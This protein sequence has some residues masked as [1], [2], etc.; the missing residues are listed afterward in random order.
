[1]DPRKDRI[2]ELDLLR[3]FAIMAV[4]GVHTITFFTIDSGVTISSVT[5]T[6]LGC[7]VSLGVPIFF[8]VSG[9]VLSLR[10]RP[11]VNYQSF[12]R[13]RGISVLAP[14]LAISVIYIIFDAFTGLKSIELSKI[15][16]WLLT[17]NASFH[18]WFIIVLLQLYLMYPLISK[19]IS[20][21]E[22][23]GLGWSLILFLFIVQAIYSFGWN[24]FSDQF[25]ANQSLANLYKR[26]FLDGVFFFV[27]GVYLGPKYDVFIGKIKKMSSSQIGGAFVIALLLNVTWSLS[28]IENGLSG[29]SY[30]AVDLIGQASAIIMEVLG[31]F[32]LLDL[33]GVIREKGHRFGMAIMQLGN[34]S[35]GIYLIHM[36]FVVIFS[37]YVFNISPSSSAFIFPVLYL[38]VLISSYLVAL[39]L[40]YLPQSRFIIGDNPRSRQRVIT[41]ISTEAFDKVQGAS[42]P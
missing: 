42:R 30:I 1:M 8:V 27:L 40:S 23:K 35:F 38:F 6:I 31:F 36:L 15:P 37:V 14:Y 25:L 39:A 33:S 24:Y 34:Y 32:F 21:L 29:F 16:L 7:L 19:S 9:L 3:G 41:P 22:G 4:I 12:I 26:I 5:W 10:Y 28:G 17:G 20:K 13:K 18:F 11:P 2:I